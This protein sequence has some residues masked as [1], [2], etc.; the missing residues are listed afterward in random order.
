M[1]KQST[2]NLMQLIRSLS[3]AEKRHFRLFAKRNQASKDESIFLQL[4][5]LLDKQ[6]KY[7]EAFLLRKISGLKKRQLANQKANL[8]RQLLTSLR[9]LAQKRSE[10][11]QI[12]EAIDF[13][14]VLYDRGLYRPALDKLAQAKSMA[15]TGQSTGLALEILEFEKLIESQYITRSLEGRSEELSQQTRAVS[16]RFSRTGE[17]S[18]LSIQMYGLYL[19]QGFA[20]SAKE[21]DG[22]QAYF[23]KRLPRTPFEQLDFLGKIFHCQ[24]HVWLCHINQDFLG[25]FRHSQRWVNLF[26]EQADMKT[27]LAPLYLKGIHNLLMSLFLNRHHVRFVEGLSVLENFQNEVDFK[28]NKNVEGLF[29]LYH[30]THLINLY[31]MEGRFSEGTVIV[32]QLADLMKQNPF[33]WDEHRLLI[34]EYRIACLYFGDSDYPNSLEYLNRIINR[35]TTDYRSDLQCFARLLSLIAHFELGNAELVEYQIRSVYR[36][37]LAVEGEQKVQREIFR[38]LR[39]TNKFHRSE[40]TS[41]FKNL[42]EKLQ[43]LEDTRFENRAFLYLDIISWLESKINGTTIQEVIREKF[44]KRNF[45]RSI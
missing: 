7:D 22:V 36:F 2:D 30:F 24:S 5:D 11:I 20:H 16:L 9:L 42:L 39:R 33:N 31:Y 37:L 29:Q 44:L 8:Y 12:R 26:A 40:L 10:D 14:R 28:Q 17:Y 27:R 19:R 32:P 35:P 13:A 45:N 15:L 1:P 18:N 23:N 34:F 3:P 4:F 38:F 41:E 6:G 25:S 43:P 21:A